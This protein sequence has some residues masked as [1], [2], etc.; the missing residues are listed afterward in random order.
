MIF[1]ERGLAPTVGGVVRCGDT[2]F[3]GVGRRRDAIL[4]VETLNSSDSTR[5]FANLRGTGRITGEAR[6]WHQSFGVS[7]SVL[8]WAAMFHRQSSQKLLIYGHLHPKSREAKSAASAISVNVFWPG[9]IQTHVISMKLPK[10]AT[11][12]KN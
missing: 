7:R 10:N 9:K 3:A 2:K 4:A 1:Q 8:G 12:D 6:C 5:V 11:P